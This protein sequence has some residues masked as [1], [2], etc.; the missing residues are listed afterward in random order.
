MNPATTTLAV[1]GASGFVGQHLCRHFLARGWSVRG[2]VRDTEDDRLREQGLKLY[3]CD[4]PDRIDPEAFRG[5]DVLIH[6]AYTIRFVSLKDARRVNEEGSSRL[7]ALSRDAAVR[8]FVFL[9]ST[10]AHPEA[11]SYYGRSK[12]A[13]EERLDP[14]RDLIFRAGLVLGPD[15]GLF[16][17]LVASLRRSALLPLFG[18]GLQPMQTVHVDDLCLAMQKAIERDLTGRYVVAEPE[19]MPLRELLQLVARKLGRRAI[20]LPLPVGPALAC[21]RFAERLRIPLPVSS[22]NLL[23]ALGLRFQPSRDDLEAI[24][25]QLRSAAESLEQLLAR[26]ED[27]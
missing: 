15:G 5:V 22:E 27:I 2:L 10:S 8:R 6:C 12:L 17:R 21:L 23:G 13:F 11:L 20:P 7:L 26:A 4:L 1:T 14:E 25:V 3:A 19:A 9:S 24:G 16:Q 18:G